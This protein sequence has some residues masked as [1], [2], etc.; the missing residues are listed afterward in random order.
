VECVTQFTYY[1]SDLVGPPIVAA[2]RLSA[3]AGRP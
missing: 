3:G 2:S 1:Y